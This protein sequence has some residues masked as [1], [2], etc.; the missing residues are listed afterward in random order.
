MADPRTPVHELLR[1][2]L[3]NGW[4]SAG[5]LAEFNRELDLLGAAKAAAKLPEIAPRPVETSLSFAQ[6]QIDLDL[7][8]LAFPA[9]TRAGLTPW[10]DA[11][12]A[13]CVRWGIDTFRE[14][15]SFLANINVESRGLTALEENLNY[16]AQRMAE[17]WPG[18]YAVNPKAKVLVPNAL[19]H[20]LARNPEKLASNVYAN[21][22]G[23]GPP[24]SG[25]GWRFRGF[26]PKQLT[27]KD[28]QSA[29]ATAMGMRVEDVPAYLRTPAGGMMSAGWFWKANDLDSKAATAGLAD[30]RRAINGG[31]TGLPEVERSF[32]RIID[33]LLRREREA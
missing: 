29:F 13:A 6:A 21:R 26:G 8:C 14:V 10:V 28:N 27:G 1:P 4:N 18:R 11:T 15:A 30:D 23:N 22:M 7:L 3:K 2:H 17:V 16:S 25:D 31:I 5:L 33:E 24:E 20:S 19:A 9:N 32:S 12:R